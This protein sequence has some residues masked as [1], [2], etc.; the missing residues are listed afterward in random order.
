MEGIVLYYN[1]NDL[2]ELVYPN[3]HLLQQVTK[4]DHFAI[5]LFVFPPL[6]Q[7]E[8]LFLLHSLEYIFQY[9]SLVRMLGI[10]CCFIFFAEV[11]KG[12]IP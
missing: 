11:S 4:N 10:D 7:A 12:F 1:I 2:L 6:P 8:Q 5:G 9:V 3:H